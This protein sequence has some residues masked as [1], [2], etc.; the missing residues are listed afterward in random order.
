MIEHEEEIYSRPAR[1]WFQSEKDKL[2]AEAISKEQYEAGFD[3]ERQ[4]KQKKSHDE[5]KPKRDKFSG[6]SRK[7]KRRKLAMEEDKEMGDSG[8][9][10]AAVRSAKKSARPTKIGIPERRT[11]KSTKSKK[12]KLARAGKVFDKDLGQKSG[13]GEGVRAKK[14][15]A[16]GGMKK[17]RKQRK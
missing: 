17:G 7:A 5:I 1:T 13:H 14:G 12:G 4:R 3:I 8:A 9:L 15:D 16:V 2:N 10:K 11:A 6:L